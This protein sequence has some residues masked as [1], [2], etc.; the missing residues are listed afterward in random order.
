MEPSSWI[1]GPSGHHP[2]AIPADALIKN[3]GINEIIVLIIIYILLLTLA[4]FIVLFLWRLYRIIH[5]QNDT[6]EN[7]SIEHLEM[8]QMRRQS[9]VDSSADI[10]SASD[11]HEHANDEMANEIADDLNQNIDASNKVTKVCKMRRS[12]SWP[13]SRFP[14][15][16]NSSKNHTTIRTPPEMLLMEKGPPS[17]NTTTSGR[18]QPPILCKR[19]HSK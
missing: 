1:M 10:N 2:L 8:I 19:S 7:V 4:F 9:I 13:L 14:S 12:L 11:A 5:H 6:N 3:P 18:D 16:N 15:S 17:L